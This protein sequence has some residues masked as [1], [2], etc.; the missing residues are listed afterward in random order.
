MR[1]AAAVAFG[2]KPAIAHRAA[3]SVK[4][5]EEIELRRAPDLFKGIC[6][7]IAEAE[8]LH[9]EEE[10]AGED[11]SV[12]HDAELGDARRASGLEE[13]RIRRIGKEAGTIDG[14]NIGMS[15][16]YL[17]DVVVESMEWK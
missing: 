1:R 2:M 17:S 7:D 14:L 9:P 13:L 4:P 15:L 5:P 12:G 3:V 6:Q 10:I 11:R 8:L 16:L